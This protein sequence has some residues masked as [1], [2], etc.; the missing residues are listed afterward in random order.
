MWYLEILC[1]ICFLQV[2]VYVLCESYI[3]TGFPSHSQIPFSGPCPLPFV[4]FISL[5]CFIPSSVTW[6]DTHKCMYMY[7]L[8]ILCIYIKFTKKRDRTSDI[9][10]LWLNLINTIIFICI[11]FLVDN[12]T[13]FGLK[14]FPLCIFYLFFYYIRV[15]EFLAFPP[16][17]MYDTTKL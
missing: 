10:L 8:R 1:F 15:I 2:L 4:L 13:S 6:H 7:A 11:Y 12:I 16:R 9:C 14:I 5:D 17:C 3:L